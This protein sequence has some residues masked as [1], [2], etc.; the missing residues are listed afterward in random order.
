MDWIF[1]HPVAINKHSSSI[2][3]R[4]NF[5]IS[6]KVENPFSMTNLFVTRSSD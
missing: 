6:T 5:P 3:Y 1:A 4:S 2:L